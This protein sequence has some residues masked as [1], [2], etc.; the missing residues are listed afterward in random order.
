MTPALSSM[1]KAMATVPIGY[2]PEPLTG[3]KIL[4]DEEEQ[5]F[6]ALD[7]GDENRGVCFP[8]ATEENDGDTFWIAE[9]GGSSSIIT[10]DND[11]TT[12]APGT[13]AAFV[14]RGTHWECLVSGLSWA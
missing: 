2:C 1:Y 4:Q 6:Q 13:M 11:S 14:S 7:A 5:R 9:T 8:G 10:N 3:T 12:I